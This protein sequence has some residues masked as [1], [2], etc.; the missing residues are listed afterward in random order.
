MIKDIIKYVLIFSTLFFVS[1]NLQLLF[2]KA[3]IALLPFNLFSVYLFHAIFSF[4]ICVSIDFLSRQENQKDQV[5]FIYLGTLVLKV[6]VFCIVFYKVLFSNENLTK[7]Q[8]V[9]MLIP[10]VIYL[11]AEAYFIIQ[12]LNRKRSNIIK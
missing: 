11:V 1:Y 10:L 3:R 8:S 6:L 2:I 5:G 7:S 9:L 12:I 4:L